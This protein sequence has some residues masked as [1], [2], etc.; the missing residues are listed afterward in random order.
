M[1]EG[2]SGAVAGVAALQKLVAAQ[3]GAQL[4]QAL[5]QGRVA[6]IEVGYLVQLLLGKGIHF[7]PL[8]GHREL[9]VVPVHW[10]ILFALG[11][12]QKGLE[13][14]YVLAEGVNAL[15]QLVPA[16]RCENPGKRLNP[17]SRRAR[18]ACMPTRTKMDQ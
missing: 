17:G 13:A 16:R 4:Q 8:L 1:V 6:K 14:R 2:L 11:P 7:A 5:V 10:Q 15:A 3:L 12:G 18:Q 9:A